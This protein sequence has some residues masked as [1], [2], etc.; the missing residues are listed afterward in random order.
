[1]GKVPSTFPWRKITPLPLENSRKNQAQSDNINQIITKID[2][3][4]LV[5]FSK[6]DIEM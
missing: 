3:F 6:W 2:D 1:M 4:Y 5:I